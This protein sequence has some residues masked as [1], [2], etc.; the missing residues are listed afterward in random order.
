MLFYLMLG[1]W[2]DIYAIFMLLIV[3]LNDITSFSP[4]SIFSR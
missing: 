2:K 3:Q 1:T 4:V